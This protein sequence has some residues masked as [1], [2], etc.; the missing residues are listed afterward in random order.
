MCFPPMPPSLPTPFHVFF[1]LVPLLPRQLHD[2]FMSYTYK[3]F[4]CS[5][6]KS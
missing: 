1:L 5:Y 2:M 4:V 6:I 3:C